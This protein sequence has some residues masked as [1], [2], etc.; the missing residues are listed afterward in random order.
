MP[1][2]RTGFDRWGQINYVANNPADQFRCRVEGSFVRWIQL[3]LTATLN[4]TVLGTAAIARNPGTLINNILI[5]KNGKMLKS[6]RFVDWIDRAFMYWGKVIPQTRD[7]TAV[8]ATTVR[9][10]IVIPFEMPL[11]REPQDTVLWVGRDDVLTIDVTWADENALVNGGTKAFTANPQLRVSGFTTTSNPAPKGLFIEAFEEFPDMGTAA[12]NAAERELIT[13]PKQNYHSAMLVTENNLAPTAGGRTLADWTLTRF[14]LRQTVNNQNAAS[15]GG[16]ALT[17]DEIQQATDMIV[18]SV[19]GIQTGLYPF[20]WSTMVDGMRSFA[21]PTAG[22]SDLR[23]ILS[24]AVAPTTG[25]IV[26][27]LKNVWEPF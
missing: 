20:Y 21:Y 7:T 23:L 13:S 22:L 25:G 27:W 14:E 11:T 4:V 6:G 1:S 19:A 24:S 2:V 15:R 3:D 26:R 9:S 17:G 16:D 12:L 5:R 8:N 18:P 10:R